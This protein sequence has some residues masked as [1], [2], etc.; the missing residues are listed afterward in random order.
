MFR[1]LLIAN[2]GEIACRVI[3]TARR[4]GIS[5]VA[6]YSQADSAAMHVGL[7]DEAFPIGPAPARESYLAI[8]KIIGVARACGAEAVHPGYGFLSE[9]PEFA[10]SCAAAGLVFIGPPAAAM[11][12]MGVKTSAK[13][14]MER[15]GAPVAPGYHG[16]AFDL[17]TLT[18]EA[19]RIGFPLLIKAAGGGGGRGMRLV[20][21]LD[22][23]P[24]AVA[25]ARREA[26]A[27]FGDERLLLEKRLEHPRH[28]EVQIFSDACGACVAFPERD[29]SVQRRRQ[30]IIEET[31]APGLSRQMRRDLRGAAVSAAKAVGYVG[32]GTVEFLVEDEAYFFLEMNTRL[33]VEHPITEMISGCDLVEWQLRVADGERLPVAQEELEFSGC[34]IEARLCAEDASSDFMPSVGEIVHFR[35]PPEQAGFRLDAGVRPGDRITHHYDSLLAKAI[36]WGEGRSEAIARLRHAL[37]AFEVAGVETNL[38]L[39]RAVL[40]SE[41]FRRGGTDI[42]FLERRLESLLRRTPLSAND[43]TF[44][45]AAAVVSWIGNLR[46]SSR[47]AASSYGDPSSPWFSGDG[48]RLN[49][50]ASSVVA[51]ELG[52]RRL[53]GRISIA[54]EEFEL[55]AG[56][57]VATVAHRFDGDRLRLRVSGIERELGLVRR[58]AQIIVF[59]EGRAHTFNCRDEGSASAS[60]KEPPP[61]LYAPIPARVARVLVSAGEKVTKGETLLILEAMKMEIAMKAPRDGQIASVFCSEGDLL[62]EGERLVELSG[63][64]AS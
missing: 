26:L 39:L 7:A 30:K 43:E 61:E 2:R 23:M 21:R 57:D 47:A 25:S 27:A 35:A 64:Q 49:A 29:C 17:Q 33:Q 41:D 8:G 38:D 63:D 9:N 10:E 36:A 48:W 13:A 34:A 12:I 42:N 45:F 59:L 54:A 32:A 15:L 3:R 55:D 37:G 46:D 22:E 28:I 53:S 5:T 58:G 1:K 6:I 4:L 60:G 19:E 44:L 24:E 52:Q 11:R 16:D 62:S 51:F 50:S 40:D 20:G 31:P 14:L 18:R 56:N